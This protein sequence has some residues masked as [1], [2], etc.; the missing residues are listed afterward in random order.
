MEN[1]TMEHRKLHRLCYRCAKKL[2]KSDGSLCEACTETDKTVRK[3][4]RDQHEKT[5]ICTNCSSPAAKKPDGTLA[6]LCEKCSKSMREAVARST[7]QLRL[8]IVQHYGSKCKHCDCDD[9]RLLDVTTTAGRRTTKDGKT[10]PAAA[11][12]RYLRD[13]KLP[14]GYVSLCANCRRTAQRT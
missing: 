13:K 14:A 4:N 12:H 10:L 3:Q 1:K 5:G 6:K 8:E 11:F 7:E 2:K 9:A